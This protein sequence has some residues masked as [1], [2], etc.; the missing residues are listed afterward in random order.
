MTS[1][2]LSAATMEAYLDG[3]L[4]PETRA[5]AEEHLGTCALCR[6]AV[7]D[8]QTVSET[9]AKTAPETCAFGA[10]SMFW[11]RLS[12][13]LSSYREHLTVYGALVLMPPVL[14]GALGLAL[15]AIAWLIQV[16]GALVW[17]GVIPPLGPALYRWAIEQA[18]NPEAPF[19]FRW[20]LRPILAGVQELGSMTITWPPH[21]RNVLHVSI[22]HVMLGLGLAIVAALFIAWAWCLLGGLAP[23]G[24][25]QP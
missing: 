24:E 14:L 5:L 2:H 7:R 9:V 16:V 11:H 6:K 23:E 22:I 18:A 12:A 15:I 13:R 21:L 17:A 10:G 25:T 4:D 20:T 19:A 1:E 8:L 3:E